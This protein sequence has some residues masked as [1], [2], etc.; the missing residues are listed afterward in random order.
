MDFK[1]TLAHL[2]D[3]EVLDLGKTIPAS[4]LDRVDIVNNEVFTT[5][6]H[7][8]LRD[9]YPV[10]EQAPEHIQQMLTQLDAEEPGMS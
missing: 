6:L 7:A 8:L 5:R 9:Y 10:L 4:D 2:T 3:G 1:G